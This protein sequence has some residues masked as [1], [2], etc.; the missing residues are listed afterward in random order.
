MVTTSLNSS[1]ECLPEV[2]DESA[3]FE[4]TAAS[5]SIL[6]RLKDKCVYMSSAIRDIREQSFK[7]FSRMNCV[8]G[9]VLFAVGAFFGSCM[10]SRKRLVRTSPTVV[11]EQ[12][13]KYEV[14]KSQDIQVSRNSQ[15]MPITPRKVIIGSLINEN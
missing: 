9:I 13:A 15:G 7:D 1:V 11:V 3:D 14:E 2:N 4:P 5:T 10:E 6:N 12:V 8:L